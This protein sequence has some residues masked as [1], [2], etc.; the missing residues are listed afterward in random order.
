M[1]NTAV[2]NEVVRMQFD[3]RQF[4]A[5]VKQSMSTL[6]KL[7]A[8]LHLDKSAQ[9]FKQIGDAAKKVN[10][11]PITQGIEG[12]KKSF[13]YMDI[14]FAT[15]VARMTND[16]I[17]AGKRI[18]SALTIDPVKTG[19]SEYETKLNAIQVMKSN[20][21]G[22]LWEINEA[23]DELNR[24]ADKTIYNFT[25]MTSNVGK[26]VA[27]GMKAGEAAK[28]VQGLANLAGASG[29]SAEDM[30]RATYQMSQA[31]GGTIRKIDW[32]SLRNANMA[33]MQ[34]KDVLK[35]VAKTEYGVD[36]DS[37][38]AAKGTFEDSLEKG[39]LTGTMFSEAMQMYS[40]AYDEATLK[41]KGYNDA[42]IKMFKD[43]AKEAAEATTSV[44]TLSQLWDVVKET[45]QS[46]WTQSWELII[47]DLEE[48]KRIFTNLNNMISGYIDKVSAARNKML[49]IWSTGKDT[50]E[51][52]KLIDKLKGLDSVKAIDWT[53]LQNAGLATKDLKNTLIEI[54]KTDKNYKVE[55]GMLAKINKDFKE[56]LSEGWLSGGLFAEAMQIYSN[57]Y[58]DA[59]LAAKG[60]TEE[61]INGFKKIA[62]AYENSTKNTLSSAGLTGREE[63]LLGLSEFMHSITEIANSIRAAF[64]DIFP[65]MTGK[66]LVEL[67]Q[68]FRKLIQALKPT[69]NEL[70]N[71]FYAMR[72]FFSVIGL[73]R[74]IIAEV[75]KALIPAFSTARDL[76]EIILQAAGFIGNLVYAITKWLRES[77]TIHKVVSSIASVLGEVLKQLGRIIVQIFR[78]IHDTGLDRFLVQLIGYLG[79]ALV[80]AIEH[81]LTLVTKVADVVEKAAPKI[82]A[83]FAG[84]VD[85]IKNGKPIEY[86][87]NKFKELGKVSSEAGKNSFISKA[88]EK[89]GKF[90]SAVIA[91]ISKAIK[92]TYEFA[93]SLDYSQGLA[94]I[95]SG[96]FG[97][98]LMNLT[99]LIKAMTILTKN[100]GGLATTI[101][102]T[103][104]KLGAHNPIVLE[105]AI[106]VGILS[107]SLFTL[108]KIPV[109][110]LW[111]G[112]GA[113][114]ALS[115]I[116]GT[117]GA[118]MTKVT[119]KITALPREV[120]LG[121]LATLL[122]MSITMINISKAVKTLS[123]INF[124]A[125]M[126]GIISLGLLMLEIAGI[127]MLI[128]KFAPKV[129]LSAVVM[130]LF[131][132]TLA[133]ATK[134]LLKIDFAALKNISKDMLMVAGI[135]GASALMLGIGLE[136][137]AFATSGIAKAILMISAALYIISKIKMSTRQHRQMMNGFKTVILS[138]IG[139]VVAVGWAGYV[140]QAEGPA[141]K[142]FTK[143]IARISTALLTMVVVMKIAETVK[144]YHRAMKVMGDIV[145]Y[146]VIFISLLSWQAANLA[147]NSEGIKQM[148]HSL[149]LIS[150]SMAIMA[151]TIT[152]I[153]AIALIPGGTKI[154]SIAGG[155][156]FALTVCVAGLIAVSKLASKVSFAPILALMLGLS[157]IFTELVILSGMKPEQLAVASSAMLE[158]ILSLMLMISMLSKISMKDAPGQ[159]AILVS[160]VAIFLAFSASMVQLCSLDWT[161]M[162]N[163]MGAIMST[164]VLMEGLV[165][166]SVGI[167][168]IM[169]AETGD[170]LMAAGS[171]TALAAA[172]LMIS[173][174]FAILPDEVA[175][176]GLLALAFGLGGLVA[177]FAVLG[178]NGA[179]WAAGITTL[180][181]SLA[182]LGKSLWVIAGAIG[183]V[184]GSLAALA[185]VFFLFSKINM[186][187]GIEGLVLFTAFILGLVALSGPI[188]LCS[189]ALLEFGLALLAMSG[190]AAIGGVGLL[191]IAS[192]LKSLANVGADNILDI[193]VGLL[194]VAGASAALAIAGAAVLFAVPGLLGIAGGLALIGTVDLV[195]MS[196]GLNM[197]A[198]AITSLVPDFLTLIGSAIGIDIFAKSIKDLEPALLI[199]ATAITTL[200]ENMNAFI[201][202]KD[203]FISASNQI[204]IG[205]EKGLVSG[206]NRAQSSMRGCANNLIST[207]CS[208]L[209]IHSPSRVF[210]DIGVY[211][212]QGLAQGEK[213][214]SDDAKQILVDNAK[215]AAQ[216]METTGCQLM[217]NSGR[218]MGETWVNDM[219]DEMD[220][221]KT[222]SKITTAAQNTGKN[223]T[224]KTADIISSTASVIANA[225]A[226]SGSAAGAAFVTAMAG[227][228]NANMPKIVNAVNG[229]YGTMEETPQSKAASTQQEK[230]FKED[231]EKAK[232]NLEGYTLDQLY[233]ADPEI[234][235]ELAEKG[236]EL[237]DKAYLQAISE[238][239]TTDDATAAKKKANKELK[240]S[241]KEDFYEV[242]NGAMDVIVWGY[243]KIKKGASYMA[244][245][246]P[247][248]TAQ[249]YIE[250]TFSMDWSKIDVSG[251]NDYSSK[252]AT[253]Q[254]VTEQ[255]RAILKGQG[256]IAF[257][258]MKESTQRSNA[259]KNV[260]YSA[261]EMKKRGW[262]LD[263]KTHTWRQYYTIIDGQKV[264]Q[265]TNDIEETSTAIDGLSDSMDGLKESTQETESEMDTFTKSLNSNLKSAM[266]YFDEFKYGTEEDKISK[267]QLLKNL[268]DQHNG[269]INWAKDMEELAHR[270]MAKDLWK[271]LAEEG[272]ASYAK[273][274][275][276]LDM[277]QKELQSAN[278]WF[279]RDLAL[280][281]VTT[282]FM[283]N[284]LQ[285]YFGESGELHD[286]MY[287]NGKWFSKGL[288]N[289]MAGDESKG[290]I[291]DAAS[292]VVKTANDTVKTDGG[293]NSP[294][295]VWAQYGVYF[296]EGLMVGMRDTM[297]VC[298]KQISNM[299]KTINRTV[300][301]GLRAD[302]FKTIGRNAMQGLISGFVSQMDQL[303]R[304]VN[305]IADR[306]PHTITGKWVIKSPSRLFKSFGMYAMEG[307]AL[308]LS[309]YSTLAE[310]AAS[311]TADNTAKTL[312]GITNS[313]LDWDTDFNPVITPTLNLDNVTRGVREINDMF[314]E[315]TLDT[316][317]ED[318][319]QNGGTT[320]QPSTTFIQNN[321]SPKH[322]S[323]IDIYRQTRNQ[324]S[325]LKGA[326]G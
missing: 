60:Y 264:V 179:M 219:A 237:H 98:L 83:F 10:F 177:T 80:W 133:L 175:G 145:G 287:E 161:E 268:E 42:Q 124:W 261:E 170:L 224:N 246:D 195:A 211:M 326:M 137:V 52:D 282:D 111:N 164:L 274:K 254:K 67:S 65:P 33:T 104:K 228:L 132:S 39:W 48:A 89:M 320:T 115:V 15:A 289:G 163:R 61:Q 304:I 272:P 309:Q 202:I 112:V 16:A 193:S 167:A 255:E 225:A 116:M 221:G 196:V 258:E 284:I 49:G 194:A 140:M 24:Y 14:A 138:M 315:T 79:N 103:L 226:N 286:K 50:E 275:A 230:K 266:N 95:L 41:Q 242:H 75:I 271:N 206:L 141:I 251:I 181:G 205:L 54:A 97:I 305:N 102:K 100:W 270:G 156:L 128:M 213:E 277:T 165:W 283:S 232:K 265:T 231:V 96:I 108:S 154:L 64:R 53:E 234:E 121:M 136:K 59:E 126:S 1:S 235:K 216:T 168:E 185:G 44:K 308:G 99:G 323:S 85:A 201:G 148:G 20:K 317:V 150:V 120:M 269:M 28:A 19:L 310:A 236:V 292:T 155:I 294:S 93:K 130:L 299:I 297:R 306:I 69:Y 8:A 183:I 84:F 45:A 285:Q 82:K 144:R 276:F 296:V 91:V 92:S 267:E 131:C 241:I 3:N 290:E 152:A 106:F 252:V 291:A 30:A 86:L 153:S 117:F 321:Y 105:L 198:M 31:M 47:G 90:Y 157:A 298:T 247:M 314:K 12:V 189:A 229:I 158:L 151:T 203:A 295:K 71:I 208:I 122:T 9:G 160:F 243:D 2:E 134:T 207:F 233:G 43:L 146:M 72:G 263:E 245:K 220:K 178:N 135:L 109:K 57:S 22:E 174:A 215:D 5:G 248:A 143:G 34:L 36:V 62:E 51:Q 27:Q 38:I 70:A 319:V 293:I 239:Y 118:V 288:A 322:L 312:N 188:S 23:L 250:D 180:A 35:E 13:T 278:D 94:L 46:G 166:L 77:G 318:P 204:G 149:L 78:I 125:A 58:N 200:V 212:M 56:S 209:G 101:S 187:H 307:L 81:I 18:A 29:A 123:G 142:Q 325:S 162:Q 21:G 311:E 281:D 210:H 300:R 217:G 173:A 129:S 88:F 199:S 302:I 313:V 244:G 182:T 303:N 26:F 262:E 159:V 74:D 222:N 214:G 4:E 147:V 11:N 114:F 37:I 192:S 260:Y 190:A 249:N 6:D 171:I 279:A 40:D 184:I 127:S 316:V 63:I 191:L 76:N 107:A 172:L 273:V 223:A 256:N 186:K 113:I 55:D 176:G 25:Q 240:E 280:P 301:D 218:K 139:L 257:N 253:V 110:K 238:M 324:L 259:L 197:F 119:A 227:V 7:K 169:K 66:R 32:N 68:G 87:I 17:T 73:V